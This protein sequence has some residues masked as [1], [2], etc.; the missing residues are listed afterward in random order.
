MTSHD[1]ARNKSYDDLHVFLASVP[2]ADKLI[3]LG[4]FNFRVGTDH[5]AW[6]G[7]LGPHGL[8]GSN[9]NALLL[10]RTCRDHRL[11]LTNTFFCLWVGD[12][13]TWMHPRSR[14]WPLQDNV[15]VQ[16]RD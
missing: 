6:R 13:A 10:L 14:H 11:I 16:R 8:D 2:K 12:E 15:L 3:V 7:V 1:E 9:D 5:A 4:G